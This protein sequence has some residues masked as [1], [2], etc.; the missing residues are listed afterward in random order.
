MMMNIF[1]TQ[2]SF[3]KNLLLIMV[4]ILFFSWASNPLEVTV[5]GVAAVDVPATS[6]I[7][8][9]TT[10]HI[11][12]SPI[13]AQANLEEKLEVLKRTMADNGVD[14]NKLIQ[15]QTQ[16]V[17][18]SSLVPG[19]T[20]Y[21]A[22]ATLGGPT[23]QLD[24]LGTLSGLLYERGAMLVSQP[25]LQNADSAKL[26]SQALKDALKDAQK[27]AASIGNKN[28]RFFR[29]VGAVAQVE[30]PTTGTFTSEGEVREGDEVAPADTFKIAKAVR[31][32]YLM[33]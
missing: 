24:R 32:T 3:F 9:L 11:N 22:T 14:Q 7:M 5:T 18:A 2:A 16:I 27:Q 10:S 13:M 6:A 28:M 19:S 20:G 31:V 23:T 15:S 30:T 29:R 17:P 4:G 33:W 8:S 1:Q 21:A 12:D 25:V 26:E